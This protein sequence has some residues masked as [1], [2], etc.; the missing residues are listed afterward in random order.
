[1]KNTIKSLMCVLA[2]AGMTSTADAGVLG[3]GVDRE[4]KTA[5]TQAYTAIEIDVDIAE[6]VI[7]CLVALYDDVELKSL[8]RAT[9][10]KDKKALNA[11]KEVFDLIG[12]YRKTTRSTTKLTTAQTLLN[13]VSA[14][15]KSN[16]KAIKIAM[17]GRAL[18]GQRMSAQNP[19]IITDVENAFTALNNFLG[20]FTTNAVASTTSNAT[21][22]QT[23]STTQQSTITRRSSRR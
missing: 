17:Y 20:G 11:L 21:V 4:T 16:Q 2:L 13:E 15:L 6:S 1:M 12:G 7:D 9:K 19:G 5:Y 18:L 23:A 22:N 14:N 8:P 10:N 3:R